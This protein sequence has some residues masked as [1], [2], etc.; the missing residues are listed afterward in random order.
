MNWLRLKSKH[1]FTEPTEHIHAVDIFDTQ[2]YDI[3]YE[4]Q[5]NI[6]HPVWKEFDQKYKTGFEFK[7]D[8]T[9][10]DKD[11]EII[12]LWFFRERSDHNHPP[13]FD[14]N[15]KSISYTANAF[16]I[17]EYKEFQIKEAKR[18]YIRRPLV[19]LDLSKKKFKEL[20]K[21]LK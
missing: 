21:R 20:V 11:K 10:I 16:L 18:K 19:Q 15:G 8:I 5:N 14:L 1:Y 12:A 2:E 17:T 9:E 6:N 3:L 4:N 13:V 7:E